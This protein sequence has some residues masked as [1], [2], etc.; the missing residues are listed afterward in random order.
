MSIIMFFKET[1]QACL[2]SNIHVLGTSQLWTWITNK[3]QINWYA[4]CIFVLNIHM[5]IL[6]KKW[7]KQINKESSRSGA[8]VVP[9]NVEELFHWKVHN[10]AQ[11]LSFMNNTKQ[12]ALNFFKPYQTWHIHTQKNTQKIHTN[13]LNMIL[14]KEESSRYEHVSLS[15][16]KFYKMISISS[17]CLYPCALYIFA[18]T[19]YIRPTLV[20]TK[21]WGCTNFGW[22]FLSKKRISSLNFNTKIFF[23]KFF[24]HLFEFNSSNFY[25]FALLVLVPYF[26]FKNL[27]VQF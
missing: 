9:Y 13:Y 11:L 16:F 6:S 14:S 15:F 12:K 1:Y 3:P 17:N 24:M 25:T 21:A 2:Y 20:W 10:D 18:K 19:L 7:E 5:E 26:K 4:I 23:G 22:F 27:W 8:C